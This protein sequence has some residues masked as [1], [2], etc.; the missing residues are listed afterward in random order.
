VPPD[1][2]LAWLRG[3][4]GGDPA[5]VARV[6]DALPTAE[7]SPASPSPLLRPIESVPESLRQIGP[8]SLR[9]VLGEG[10]FGVV[11]LADQSEPIPRRVALKVLKPHV[12]AGEVV[13]RFEQERRMLARLDHPSIAHVLDAGVSEDGRPWFALE[14]VRGLPLLRHCDEARLGVDDRLRLFEEICRAVQ[15]AHQNGVI[16]RDLKPSNILVSTGR[17]GDGTPR[18]GTP[19]IIDFGIAEALD[20]ADPPR[21]D[22]ALA[23]DRPAG[24]LEFMAPEQ[25]LGREVDTRSDI[26]AL[27]AILFHLLSGALP[28]GEADRDDP[29]AFV[30]R[31]RQQDPRPP[32]AVV[33]AL[34]PAAAQEAAMRRSTTPARLVRA[35]RGDLDWITLRCLQKDRGARY[36]SASDLAADLC[37]HFAH[38]PVE[39]APRRFLY[40]LD[41]FVRRH[42]AAVAAAL[43]C[44]VMLVTTT[45]LVALAL[46]TAIRAH[47]AERAA[48]RDA[49]RASMNANDA[50]SAVV[51]LI[52]SI[53]LDR[54][55]RG[56]A[57]TSE[58][59]LADAR[60]AILEPFQTQPRAQAQVRV[61]LAKALLSLGHAG[62]ASR[63]VTAAIALLG[64]LGAEGTSG[65]IDALRT[66]AAI[67]EQRARP[68]DALAALD[69][70]ASLQREHAP[71]DAE[72][73]TELQL[74]R[75]RVL[76]SSGDAAG[77]LRA[78]NAARGWIAR[79]DASTPRRRAAS[80]AAFFEAQAL[81]LDG[82]WADALRAIQPNLDFNRST[83]PGHWWMAESS[84]VQAAGLIGIGEVDEG[85]QILASVEG[86]LMQALPPGASPRR[87]IC[88]LV[89]KAFEARGLVED[90]NH[91]R[92]LASR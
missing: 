2:R 14:F 86:P 60:Q 18:W 5:L 80:S 27:G 30:E 65:V 1:E 58:Q 38:R 72:D 48:R 31:L 45:I 81:L 52:T 75:A 53:S 26:Y 29:T 64:T 21:A 73:W 78:V 91:W 50:L 56:V 55:A 3:A 47:E 24:T 15:H 34:P 28:M 85:R 84:A 19:K 77:A 11:Y 25:A 63:E 42:Q 36:D 79:I 39:A 61:A 44:A 74:D 92:S 89:A 88:T 37:R 17:P 23:S 43:L 70:A 22:A 51:S 4:C 83:M 90:A 10:A 69:R 87:T 49:E 12:S 71:E 67:D 16:H 82:R 68:D 57:T 20:A 35:L 76:I 32:S 46:R 66:Q 6:A 13:A 8:Y 33:A 59:I 7:G 9:G 40:R 54:T 62:A 41:R